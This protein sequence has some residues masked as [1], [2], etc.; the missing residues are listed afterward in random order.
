M[1]SWYLVRHGQTQWN[2]QGRIQ[3]HTDVPLGELGRRN[4]RAQAKRLDGLTFAA[5]Y[6]SD[7]SRTVETAR[8]L[9]NDADV[10]VQTDPNLREFSYGQWEGL[11]PEEVQA[12]DSEGFG[13]RFNQ[14]DVDFAAPGGESAIQLLQRVHRFYVKAASVHGPEENILVVAHGGS[15]R[16]LTLCLLGLS[17]EH[18][19][20]FRVDCASLS[21]IRNYFGGRVLEHWNITAPL[22]ADSSNGG[23]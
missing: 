8:I 15:I 3:G 10:S 19:W 7:L 1:G 17:D 22:C 11:T 9:V 21:V 16:A 23:L 2:L 14:R 6:A 18:F 4:V 12:R 20:R 5:V 13:Q